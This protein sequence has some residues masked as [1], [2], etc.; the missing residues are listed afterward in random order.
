[1]IITIFFIILSIA[2]AI[3]LPIYL[4]KKNKMYSFKPSTKNGLKENKKT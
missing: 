2:L 4:K 1:M 3:V